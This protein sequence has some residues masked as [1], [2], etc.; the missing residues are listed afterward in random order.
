MKNYFALFALI[1]IQGC[2]GG[3]GD[4]S[5]PTPGDGDINTV[6]SFS[7]FPPTYFTTYNETIELAGSDNTGDEY[8]LTVTEQTLDETTIPGEPAISIGTRTD[9]ENTTTSQNI[10]LTQTSY[11]STS[12]T[13][14]RF[15]GTDEIRPVPAEAPTV[16]PQ[17]AIIGA[18]GVIGRYGNNSGEVESSSWRLEDGPNGRANLIYQFDYTTSSG[19]PTGSETQ[20]FLIDVSGN[21][22]SVTVEFFD[23][24]SGLTV[25]L[26]SI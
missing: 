7:L 9:L 22:F 18:S 21:R 12:A 20:T 10:S 5:T 1:I 24:A 14:R 8:I 17:T 4:G 23:V 16:I 13:D 19:D 26:N 11:F 3:G 25:T 2:S 6:T 15:L